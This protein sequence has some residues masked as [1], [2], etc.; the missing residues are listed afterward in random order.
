M[1]GAWTVSGVG[2]ALEPLK[3]ESGSRVDHRD[4]TDKHLQSV[5]ANMDSE[6]QAAAGNESVT[7][8][9]QSGR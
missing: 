6:L 9:G 3:L 1:S 4:V 7:L 5:W 2:A 8:A